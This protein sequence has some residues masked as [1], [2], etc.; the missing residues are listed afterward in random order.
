MSTRFGTYS[1]YGLGGRE[2]FISSPIQQFFTT[3]YSHEKTLKCT[4]GDKYMHS[5]PYQP[6]VSSYYL[7]RGI[8]QINNSNYQQRYLCGLQQES[9][10]EFLYQRDINHPLDYADVNENVSEEYADS[11]ESKDS[12]VNDEE[13]V[14][15]FP[16]QQDL[17][18]VV[19]TDPYCARCKGILD[20]STEWCGECRKIYHP[21]CLRI[22]G[23][24][25]EKFLC[26][27]CYKKS[28]GTGK[29]IASTKKRN[30]NRTYLE[31]DFND[32][33][34]YVPQIG[35]QVVF[36]YQGYEAFMK[37]HIQYPLMDQD[38]FTYT[39]PTYMEIQNIE[40]L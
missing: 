14:S 27:S 6:L 13:L 12:D 31:M 5:Y 19:E 24:E 15:H 16:V 39:Q 17:E 33:S 26:I 35:D 30:V 34:R 9:K 7:S 21:L 1:V 37:H 38:L 29:E 32:L 8:P 11:E 4:L 23:L 2:E 36:F 18:L 28:I 10:I 25:A 22:G 40:Y 20:E 3:D